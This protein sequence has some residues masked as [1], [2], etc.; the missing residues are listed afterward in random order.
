MI[1]DLLKQKE[2]NTNK[3]QQYYFDYLQEVNYKGIFGVAKFSNVYNE[4]LPVQQNKL[5]DLLKQQFD[6]YLKTGSIV[7]LGIFYY[8]EIIDSIN[9]ETKGILD[10]SR[11]NL[12]SD[13][14]VHLNNML[15]KI[16]DDVA[17]NFNGFSL[18]PTTGVRVEDIGNV[19]DY[20]PHTISH[21]V[22]AEHAGLG[23]RGKSELII[24]KENGPAVRFTSILFNFPLIQGEKIENMCGECNACLDICPILK[25]KVNLENYRENCRKF[26]IILGLTEDVCG[27]CIKACYRNSI[28]KEMFKLAG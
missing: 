13:E 18:P 24:T 5:K 8:P 9:V 15:K 14:Y 3:I 4:L 1:E 25:N 7:S 12:Y 26:M 21:R 17:K 22:V 10:K 19:I 27:K 11:W 16:G 28:I 20:Y 2:K 23:W 6:D